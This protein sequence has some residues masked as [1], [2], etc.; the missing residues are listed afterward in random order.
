MKRYTPFKG[1]ANPIS[2]AIYIKTFKSNAKW[3][4]I[5]DILLMKITPICNT[6]PVFIVSFFVFATTNAGRDAFVLPYP[7]M[8][9]A[10]ILL[11]LFYYLIILLVFCIYL[12]P[13]FDTKNPMGYTLAVVMEFIVGWIVDVVAMCFAIFAIPIVSILISMAHGLK[14]ELKSVNKNAKAKRS[15]LSILKQFKQI[16]EFHSDVKQFSCFFNT[17]EI[18]QKI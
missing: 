14:F 18:F 9:V 5:L 1:L 12:R 16:V 3:I 2:K 4:K 7:V 13:P 11:Y 10:T 8:Q 15:P 17:L 6:F